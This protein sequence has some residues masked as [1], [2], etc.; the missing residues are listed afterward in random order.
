MGAC[1]ATYLSVPRA[2]ELRLFLLRHSLHFA[3]SKAH[4][5]LCSC[6]DL[7]T[8]RDDTSADRDQAKASTQDLIGMRQADR[9][10]LTQEIGLHTLS[11]ARYMQWQ[12][13]RV[14]HEA[15]DD[16][17]A[18]HRTL[19][20]EGGGVPAQDDAQTAGDNDELRGDLRALREK[21][22]LSLLQAASHQE[23]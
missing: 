14:A 20:S 10:L 15:P 12:G 18:K 21:L 13:E 1:W 6:G 11:Q 9:L 2:E 22:T 17:D 23:R 7:A 19:L 4:R 16:A 3:I 8:T 5:D